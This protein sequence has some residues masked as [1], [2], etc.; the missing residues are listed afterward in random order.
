MLILSRKC[1]ETIFIDHE[2]TVTVL[3][4]RNNRVKLGVV[5]PK[6]VGV[7]REEAYLQLQTKKKQA[8]NTEPA[9]DDNDAAEL[10]GTA[11]IDSQT[12]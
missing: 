1:G 7:F 2:I 3:E 8:G 5:A 10:I 6:E 4:A 11:T 12:A 9:N